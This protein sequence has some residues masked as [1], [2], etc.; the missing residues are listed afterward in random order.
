[1]WVT[2]ILTVVPSRYYFTTARTQF[3]NSYISNH[4]HSILIGYLISLWMA[5][6]TIPIYLVIST[7][8]VESGGLVLV[9]V[10]DLNLI[11]HLWILLF[12]TFVLLPVLSNYEGEHCE[13]TSMLCLETYLKL[14]YG[15]SSKGIHHTGS[16]R[17]IDT[18]SSSITLWKAMLSAE[19]ISYLDN[20]K[21]IGFS[22]WSEEC[23]AD[24]QFVVAG[25]VICC[26]RVPCNWFVSIR[27]GNTWK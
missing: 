18:S 6:H 25:I 12:K 11:M 10:M 21:F 17:T 22:I 15:A 2:I 13:A 16:K 9:D 4:Y 5:S 26:L 1:M 8:Q 23:L 14:T 7:L 20:I 24:H 3:H 27:Q 19:L